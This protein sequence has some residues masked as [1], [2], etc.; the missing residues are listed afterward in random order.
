[1]ETRVTAATFDDEVLAADSPVLVDF[2][3][4]WCRPCHAVAPILELIAQ[5]RGLKLVKVDY[6]HEP[7]LAERFGVQSIPN[8]ILFEDGEPRGRAIGALPKLTLER[9]LGLP[10]RSPGARGQT[11]TPR[12][13]VTTGR[14][15]PDSTGRVRERAHADRDLPRLVRRPAGATGRRRVR[16]APRGLSASQLDLDRAT[17]PSSASTSSTAWA[18]SMPEGAGDWV[19][20]TRTV[21]SSRSRDRLA[22]RPRLPAPAVPAVLPGLTDMD[23]V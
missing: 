18:S 1:M 11:T 19:Q 5:E 20:V 9:A 23:V 16:C 10:C 21:S 13:D 7:Q 14:H 6:D 4:D 22:Q 3:A 17:H 12:S 2:W 15:S 8:M